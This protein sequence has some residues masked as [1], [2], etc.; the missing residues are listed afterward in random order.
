MPERER[1]PQIPNW[2]ERERKEDLAWISENLQRFWA[3]EILHYAIGRGTDK[4]DGSTCFI[5]RALS[6]LGA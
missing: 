1:R 2:A 4:A 3:K 5:W 6:E